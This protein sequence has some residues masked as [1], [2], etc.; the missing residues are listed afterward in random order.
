MVKDMYLS[1]VLQVVLLA[2]VLVAIVSTAHAAEQGQIWVVYQGEEQF[3]LKEARSVPF[4][5]L[6][7]LR[8][9][10][11][12]ARPADVWIRNTES[13]E[14]EDLT[15][16]AEPDGRYWTAVLPKLPAKSKTEITVRQYLTIEEG[17][18][19]E[20]EKQVYRMLYSIDGAIEEGLIPAKA[21]VT[22]MKVNTGM[23]LRD[24]FSSDP[25]INKYMI[26]GPGNA[27]VLFLDSLISRV[28]TD[29]TEQDYRG[30]THFI[31]DIANGYR[32]VVATLFEFVPIKADSI[33]PV[34]PDVYSRVQAFAIAHASVGDSSLSVSRA[35]ILME[36][37]TDSSPLPLDKDLRRDLDIVFQN[38]FHWSP[39]NLSE[40]DEFVNQV[41]TRDIKEEY[42]NIFDLVFEVHQ[43]TFTFSSVNFPFVTSDMLRYGTVDFVTAYIGGPYRQ[44]RGFATFTFSPLGPTLRTPPPKEEPT[45]TRARNRMLL[46]IGYSVAGGEDDDPNFILVGTSFRLSRIAS[47]TIGYAA[48]D[49][50][51]GKGAWSFGVAG[52]L[53]V[54]PLLQD[55]FTTE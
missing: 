44:S 23:Y 41:L 34:P 13:G 20:L 3:E 12:F 52:D 50:D 54:L 24:E 25:A 29:S 9:Y 10:G 36:I 27:D 32:M 40:Y 14:L 18:L 17:A 45:E 46:S 38:H 42:K 22:E 47:L 8:G 51:F 30:L 16:Q 11:P 4:A 49:N 15:V 35:N 2:T 53:T 5:Q 7:N 31:D 37:L 26:N 28:Y 6:A 1:Q 19:L 55:M 48:P 39:D 43:N 33:T 21:S